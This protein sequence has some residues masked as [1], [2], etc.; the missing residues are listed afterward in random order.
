MYA[1]VVVTR[2]TH[3]RPPLGADPL[4]DEVSRLRSFTYRV[5]ERLVD[6]AAVGQLVQVP[7]G[8]GSALGVIVDLPDRPPAGLVPE[9][10]RDL[11][12]ILDPL[13]VVTPH[14]IDLA[15]WI[16]Q[17]YLTPLSQAVRLMLPPGLAE[18]TF[19]VVGRTVA[20]SAAGLSGDEAAA[21]AWLES[22]GG[23]VRLSLFL[24]RLDVE[25]PED[26]LGQLADRGLVETH[27]AFIPPKAAPPRVQFV[28]LLAGER[29]LREALPRL[30]RPSV[31]ADLLLALARRTDAPMTLPELCALVGC[32]PAPVQA[33]ERKG[34]VEISAGRTLLVALPLGPGET[35]PIPK[36]A[37]RRR[38]ALEALREGSAPADLQQFRAATGVSAAVLAQL[39]QIGLVRRIVEPPLVLLRLPPE[40]VLGKVVE[41]RHA[42]PEWAVLQALRGSKGRVWVGGLYAE[43]G[44]DLTVLQR[45]AQKGL[46]GLH[47]EETALPRSATPESARRLTTEQE[48]AWRRLEARLS[49]AEE[50]GEPAVVLLHG[51][52]GSG[53]TE[54][55]LEALATV[56]EQGRRAIV[57]VP[58]IS[59]TAQTLRRFESRFPGRVALLHSQLS[60]GQRYQAWDAV[61]HGQADILVGPRSALLAPVSRLG[62]IIVDEAHD[63]SFKQDEPI[64]L[65]PYDAREAAVALGRIAGAAVVLG[66]ATPD[67][68]HYYRAQTGRYTLLTLPH[69][70]LPPPTGQDRP[71]V[72]PLPPVRIVDLRQELR[73]GNRSILSRVL[74]EALRQAL[75]AGDQ[76]I[77]YLNRRGAATFVLCRDCGYVARCPNCDVPLTYHQSL[78]APGTD[79]VGVTGGATR[80]AA[81][82]SPSARSTQRARP[83]AGLPKG[84]ARLVCHRCSHR[85]A[86][87]DRC[88]ACG[89]SH[90]RFFGLGTERVEG[91][92]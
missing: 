23:R 92:P 86:A 78:S 91:R 24:S 18:R 59:L 54:I 20:A 81:A 88:P 35:D 13:P 30:G 5:A 25:N 32:G 17:Q 53:K 45:L 55:Y 60:L 62:L 85:Q 66:T 58:E 2:P 33:L 72:Q 75:A 38:A 69:R 27:Y 50:A 82:G 21:L 4:R 22:Q 67:L 15:R 89:S 52:T 12:A 77:L 56:L 46:V 83:P 3:R 90:I 68:T 7:L 41:L 49:G 48:A 87:P 64:P 14:Q 8:S 84:S 29:T 61:R 10:I 47:A 11:E 71:A 74:Q 9:A 80:P 39:E 40:Q 19:V 42:G 73:A 16:A 31:Q 26:L 70:V 65:P 79:A 6:G 51:V 1:D 76:A 57:L 36:G 28:S 63:P 44:A 34:W 37:H 43:T